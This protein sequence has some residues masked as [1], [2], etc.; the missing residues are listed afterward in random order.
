MLKIGFTVDP[1]DGA[2]YWIS[3]ET[4]SIMKLLSHGEIKSFS[5]S[6]TSSNASAIIVEG[7][8]LIIGDEV[9]QIYAVNKLTGLHVTDLY[10]CSGAISMLKQTKLLKLSQGS[11]CS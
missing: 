9:G 5:S 10:N 2:L 3:S 11:S 8:N 4:N 1:E 6:F 7:E